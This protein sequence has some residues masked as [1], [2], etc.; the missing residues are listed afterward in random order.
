MKYS[1]AD[2]ENMDQRYRAQFVNSLSGFKSANLVGTINAKRVHNLCVVNSVFHVGASPA[3]LGMVMRPHTVRRD[4]FENI[5]ETGCY[6][7]NHIH[8]NIVGAAHQTSARYDKEA[9]E[10][11]ETGLTPYFSDCFTAPYVKESNIK[12]GMQIEQIN[13]VEANETQIVIG[14]VVE[15]IIDKQAVL[16]DG[17]IDLQALDSV[18]IASLDGYYAPKLINRYKYAKPENEPTILK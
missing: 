12:I 3:M 10:F 1:L 4:T 18:A 7:L 9:S 14:R 11:C 13:P 2:I 8:S 16:A 17:F 5:I 6:T 15:V